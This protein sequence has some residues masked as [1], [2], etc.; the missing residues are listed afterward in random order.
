MLSLLHKVN[1]LVQGMPFFV[2]LH[3]NCYKHYKYWQIFYKQHHTQ[4]F[5]SDGTL[6]TLLSLKCR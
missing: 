1:Q 6:N 5:L 3:H 2:I 4:F